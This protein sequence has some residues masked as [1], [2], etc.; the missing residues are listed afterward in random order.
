MCV[1][2]CQ[3]QESL[4]IGVM[5]FLKNVIVACPA[6]NLIFQSHDTYVDRDLYNIRLFLWILQN[7]SHRLHSGLGWY[8]F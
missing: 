1:L 2:V 7:N 4:L 3:V 6:H 5:C 8:K